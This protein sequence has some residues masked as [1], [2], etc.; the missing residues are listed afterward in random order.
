MRNLRSLCT[1]SYICISFKL[2]HVY[3]PYVGCDHAMKS[4]PM[5]FK[6]DDFSCFVVVVVIVDVYYKMKDKLKDNLKKNKRLKITEQ[7][8]EFGV[9]NTFQVQRSWDNCH[10]FVLNI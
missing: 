2:V 5:K 6:V 8:Q 10:F 4:S 9:N 3:L 1:R 7:N